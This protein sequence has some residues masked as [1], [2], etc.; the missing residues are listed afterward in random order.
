MDLMTAIESRRT[1]RRFVGQPT[2][3]QINRLL[4]AGSLAPSAGNK[5]AWFV[6]VVTDPAVTAQ[7]GEIKKRQNAYMHDE[8]E[9]SQ[10]RLQVQRDAFN[11][12]TSL[13]FYT[14]APEIRDEH[15]Y[16]MGSV[17]LL[18][19]NLCLA[20]VPEGL[21]SQIVAFWGETEL[22]VNRLLG[23]PEKYRQVISVN[24]GVPDPSYQPPEKV[25]K[26][27]AKWIFKE[28]WPAT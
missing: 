20:A 3:E 13:V 25:I 16:D 23:V 1:T 18:V 9:E 10:A 8:S 12:C 24:V 22:D 5:Q 7:L 21:G 27:E 6:V 26:S 15:R 2:E 14:Y 11:N 17:W 4:R 28:K 19:E